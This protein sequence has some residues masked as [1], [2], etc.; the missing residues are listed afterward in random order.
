MTVLETTPRTFPPLLT[1]PAERCQSSSAGADEQDRDLS[2]PEDWLARALATGD[3][4]LAESVVLLL[5][6]REGLPAVHEALARC[7][8]RAQREVAGEHLEAITTRR[9]A[10]TARALLECLPPVTPP[11][12]D[13]GRVVL[14]TPAGD[15][16][17][18]DLTVLAHQ[19]QQAGFRT[20]V[21]D[22]LPLPDLAAIAARPDTL[23]VVLRAHLPWSSAGAE[24][25]VTALRRMTPHPLLAV[26]GPGTP[27]ASRGHWIRTTDAEDLVRALRCHSLALSPRESAVLRAVASGRTNHEIAHELG[28]ATGTVRSHLGRAFAKTGTSHRTA[29]ATQAQR[30][31]WL[32]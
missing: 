25:A 18:L 11:H 6:R 30:Q 9:T 10:T 16:R 1:V 12:R 3:V 24:R 4:Q 29:A 5:W 15:R 8:R 21:V 19:V 7:L 20:L 13:R 14:A 27:V 31:G 26:C 28:I 2:G 32:N 22:D 17:L 23:A